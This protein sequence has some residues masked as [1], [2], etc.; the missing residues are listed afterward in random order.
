MPEQKTETLP[1]SQDSLV[2]NV[3]ELAI[4]ANKQY[5]L[6]HSECLAAQNAIKELEQ[7]IKELEQENAIL[8]K[9]QKAKK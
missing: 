3:S 6:L 8:K 9:N 2:A 7:E 4:V 1:Q 5:K